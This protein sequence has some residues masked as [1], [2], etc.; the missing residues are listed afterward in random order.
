LVIG[1]AMPLVA[2][3]FAITLKPTRARMAAAA[4]LD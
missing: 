4:A 2:A 3:L 1:V